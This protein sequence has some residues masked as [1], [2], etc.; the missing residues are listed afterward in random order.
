MFLKIVLDPRVIHNRMSEKQFHGLNEHVTLIVMVF[1]DD[2]IFNLGEI[3]A[4]LLGSHVFLDQ[5][6]YTL[7]DLRHFAQS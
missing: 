2:Y 7:I 3:Q 4:E 6:Q 1:A 5:K